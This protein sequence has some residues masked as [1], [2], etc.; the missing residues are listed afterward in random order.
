M[1]QTTEQPIL[2]NLDLSQIQGMPSTEHPAPVPATQLQ[3][4]PR[5]TVTLEELDQICF[6]RLQQM[7]QAPQKGQALTGLVE[8]LKFGVAPICVAGVLMVSIVQAN[9]PNQ[10]MMQ[11]AEQQTAVAMVAARQKPPN[12]TCIMLFGQCPEVPQQQTQPTM[13]P[14]Q[15]VSAPPE[16]PRQ[17]Q[18]GTHYATQNTNFRQDPGGDI[19][20]VIPKGTPVQYKGE[21]RQLKGSQ[22]A[23]VAVQDGRAGWVASD[24][25]VSQAQ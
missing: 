11:M 22:W 24:F 25:L 1:Q 19:R 5:L 18:F 8:V 20:F 3:A 7:Q 13:P 9:K 17:P 21:L 12:V 14:V 4:P 2:P 16:R 23:K 10:A 6:A 15:T